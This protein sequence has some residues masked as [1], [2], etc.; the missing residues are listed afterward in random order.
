M[1]STGYTRE[2]IALLLWDAVPLLRTSFDHYAFSLEVLT[3]M[4][5]VQFTAWPVEAAVTLL[6]RGVAE[7]RLPARFRAQ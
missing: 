5:A 3:A 4:H 6:D 7:G 2:S 1:Q